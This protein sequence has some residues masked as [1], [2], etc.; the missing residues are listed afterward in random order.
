MSLTTRAMVVNVSIG[1]WQ[2]YRLDKEASRKVTTEASAHADA[3]R[4]NKHLVP[5]EALSAV[6]TAAGAVRTHLYAKTLPWKDNGDRLLTRAMYLDF[7]QEHG[8]LLRAF[9]EAVEKFLDVAYPTA[10]AQAEFRMGDLFKPEDYPSA[11][12]LKRKFYINLDIDPVTA[13]DDFRVTLDAEHADEVKA[14]IERAMHERIGKA[15]SDIYLRLSDVV[16]HFATK[17]A[18][19]KAVF[20]DTTLTNITELVE[21]IPGLNVLDD[22]ALNQLGEEIKA[23]LSGI[24]PKDLRKNK[25]VRSQ[26]A[27]DAEAIMAK[28]KGFMTAVGTD[29]QQLAA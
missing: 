19:D 29:D 24:E 11:H 25:E 14:Q 1:I 26:A 9:D 4:V 20:R 8:N 15:M 6:V 13:A 22:P 28:M 10:R 18:D 12:E 17:M 3:A 21:L 2:G 27:K 5:K 16:G 7:I 23:K